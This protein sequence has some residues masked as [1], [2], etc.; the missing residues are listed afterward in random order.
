[1]IAITTQVRSSAGVNVHNAIYVSRVMTVYSRWGLTDLL[2]EMRD[3]LTGNLLTNHDGIATSFFWLLFPEGQVCERLVSLAVKSWDKKEIS[4]VCVPLSIT[5]G[6]LCCRTQDTLQ[7][8][9]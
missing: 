1:V 3:L 7:D 6:K 4:V 2:A 9:F 5:T 8:K